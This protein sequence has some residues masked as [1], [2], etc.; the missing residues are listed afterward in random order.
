MSELV[1]RLGTPQNASPQRD[2]F[3]K[4]IKSSITIITIKNVKHLILRVLPKIQYI[5]D[6]FV[7]FNIKKKNNCRFFNMTCF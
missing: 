7:F 5:P 1:A 3:K 6:T 4:I 2:F